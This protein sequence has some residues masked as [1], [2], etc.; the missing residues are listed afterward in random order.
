[1]SITA[2][3]EETALY[4]ALFTAARKLRDLDIERHRDIADSAAHERIFAKARVAE[5]EVYEAVEAIEAAV[6]ARAIIREV[7]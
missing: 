3:D 6:R 1:M 2:I 7:S 4:R 5:I